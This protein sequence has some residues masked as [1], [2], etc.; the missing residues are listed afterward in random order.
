MWVPA[1]LDGTI[2]CDNES[3][4]NTRVIVEAANMPVTHGADAALAARGATVVPDILANAGGVIASY[5]EWVQN[6][7]QMPW[8][9]ETLL[10]RLEEHLTVAWEAVESLRRKKRMDLRTAAYEI[11]VQRVLRAIELRGF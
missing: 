6:I 8:S 4:L 10:Q 9:R 7:Q 5:F 3:E 11:A 2:N 1:A